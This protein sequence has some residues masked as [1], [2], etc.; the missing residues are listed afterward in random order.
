M[1]SATVY[2]SIRGDI[3]S[4]NFV[5]LNTPLALLAKNSEGSRVY[6]MTTTSV[7]ER[8]GRIQIADCGWSAKKVLTRRIR[9]GWP[10][11]YILEVGLQ[12]LVAFW[13]LSCLCGRLDGCFWILSQ[14]LWWATFDSNMIW[15]SNCTYTV[16]SVE[17]TDVMCC[18]L[19]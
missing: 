16:T 13:I 17:V 12:N 1:K 4:Q 19:I 5:D 10:K 3:F 7:R 15:C 18:D 11:R 14:I 8:A 2:Y 9:L 6:S